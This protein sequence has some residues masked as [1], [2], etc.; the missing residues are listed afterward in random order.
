MGR[1]S[2]ISLSE[3]RPANAG[4]LVASYPL[5]GFGRT[6]QLLLGLENEL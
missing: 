5:K 2:V 3:A 6:F 1:I 4:T